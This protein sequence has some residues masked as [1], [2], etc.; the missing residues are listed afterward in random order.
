MIEQNEDIQENI[1]VEELEKAIKSA[2]EEYT[3]ALNALLKEYT[4]GC[5]E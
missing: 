4:E 3:K 2:I 5:N 1:E